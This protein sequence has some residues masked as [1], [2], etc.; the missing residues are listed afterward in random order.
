MSVR[1]TN[2]VGDRDD[3]RGKLRIPVG[4]TWQGGSAAD[5]NGARCR[6]DER[7]VG[8]TVRSKILRSRDS[9]PGGRGRSL[10]LTRII[11]RGISSVVLSSPVK[12]QGHT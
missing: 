10:V 8:L 4:Y 5:D 3:G 11:G 9:D 12:Y 6:A 7:L 2:Q 1:T